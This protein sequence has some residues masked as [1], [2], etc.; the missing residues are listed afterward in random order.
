MPRSS[1]PTRS[2]SAP[3]SSAVTS[4]ASTGPYGPQGFYILAYGGV[5]YARYSY[6]YDVQGDNHRTSAYA[7]DQWSAGRLTLNIGLRLDH[8][9]G[10]SPVLKEDGLQAE[11]CV[12]PAYRRRLRPR[13]QAVTPW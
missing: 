8:I 4:A 2:S 10:Y 1:A 9:R 3:R 6:G 5:P 11:G 12:G 13:A 7:Q